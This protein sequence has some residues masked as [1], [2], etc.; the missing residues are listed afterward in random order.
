LAFFSGEKTSK[1]WL[2]YEKK[3]KEKEREREK[4]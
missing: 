2:I 3:G 1:K 4:L